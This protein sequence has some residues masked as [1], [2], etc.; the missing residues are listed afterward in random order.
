MAVPP[1]ALGVERRTHSSIICDYWQGGLKDLKVCYSATQNLYEVHFFHSM[2]QLVHTS[3]SIATR[4]WCIQWPEGWRHD[5]S[6]VQPEINLLSGTH[7]KCTCMASPIQDCL[8]L[9]EGDS[10]R[11]VCR[12][13]QGRGCALLFGGEVNQT[14]ICQT[15]HSSLKSFLF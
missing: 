4:I 3:Q 13:A 5:F 1:E 11:W 12:K 7:R 8:M 9:W 6:S 14:C 15:N 10:P 2:F